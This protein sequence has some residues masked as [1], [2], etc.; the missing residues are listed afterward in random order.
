MLRALNM[1][2]CDILRPTLP[3][4]EPQRVVVMMVVTEFQHEA[5][6][7][8]SDIALFCGRATVVIDQSVCETLRSAAGRRS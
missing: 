7:A 1:L 6:R 4:N 8:A 2:Q 5:A 3:L